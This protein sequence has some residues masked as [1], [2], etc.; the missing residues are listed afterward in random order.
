MKPYPEIDRGKTA[1]RIR[2][3]MQCNRLKPAD[4]KEY[5]GLSCVQTIYR[6]LNGTNIPTIDNL[7]ALSALFCVRIDDIVD[8]D[9]PRHGF[10]T[11]ATAYYYSLTAWRRCLTFLGRAIQ[12][13]RGPANFE[14]ALTER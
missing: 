7:Y 5:L 13:V 1:Q 12:S 2:S 14:A 6:W 11:R 4:I 9:K 3:L 10:L 8:G